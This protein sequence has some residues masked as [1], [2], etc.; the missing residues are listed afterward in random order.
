MAIST[1]PSCHAHVQT[2]LHARLSLLASLRSPSHQIRYKSRKVHPAPD[3]AYHWDTVPPTY[4]QLKSATAF[5]QTHPPRKLWTATEW[6]RQNNQPNFSSPTNNPLG[7]QLIPEVAF[8]G[9]SNA[10]KSSLLN[11]LL[12][13]PLLNRVGQHPGKTTTMHAWGLSASNPITGGAG[14]GGEMDV[15]LAVLDMPG[16]GFGSRGEW[17]HEIVTYLNNRRQLRRA[18]VLIDALHGIKE[19]DETMVKM[20]RSK[21]ISYQ[22]VVSKADRVLDSSKK[23]GNARLQAFFEHVRK[24]LVE[25]KEHQ[26][27]AGLGEILAVGELGDGKNNK[28]VKTR[29]MLGVE[30]VRWAI[31]VATGLEEW[32]TKRTM[33]KMDRQ[34]MTENI[35]PN[36]TAE[37]NTPPA[38]TPSVWRRTLSRND[39][40]PTTSSSPNPQDPSSKRD[41]PSISYLTRPDRNTNIYTPRQANP[42]DFPSYTP[43]GGLAELEAL[44]SSSSSSRNHNPKSSNRSNRSISSPKSTTPTLKSKTKNKPEKKVRISANLA[45]RLA[46]RR[47]KKEL[48]EMA[49]MREAAQLMGQSMD[50]RAAFPA[51]A[52]PSTARRRQVNTKQRWMERGRIS[53]RR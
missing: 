34:K 38:P 36:D 22:V 5:F 1:C 33:G 29:K 27:V 2:R 45:A 48:K 7:A 23:S 4:P 10:G 41:G 52:S 50:T 15:R 37:L 13:D 44:S 26:G 14:P 3:L 32:A 25:M 39:N 20:L 16:Y 12:L 51:S 40:T 9:R 35:P 18:F 49:A 46:W 6:R 17:G 30:Q 47:E 53:A 8:L 43:I 28:K 24:E 31:L 21:G 42:S 19:A 11:A